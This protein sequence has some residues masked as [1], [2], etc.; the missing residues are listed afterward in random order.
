MGNALPYFY[1]AQAIAIFTVAM[2]DDGFPL[3]FLSTERTNSNKTNHF[4]A[5]FKLDGSLNIQAFSTREDGTISGNDG[6]VALIVIDIAPT[7]NNG[8]YPVL[9]K[10]IAIADQNSVTYTTD[11]V[12]TAITIDGVAD[13]RIVL[14][15]T[16]ASIPEGTTE[17]VE[18]LVKRTIKSD[19][20]STLCLPFSMTEDQ[21]T[22]AFGDDVQLAEFIDY[23]AEYD[24]DAVTSISVNFENVN[25]SN[26]LE[27]NWPYLIK[28]SNLV[29]EFSLTAKV[30]PDEDAAVAEYD[31]G[32]TGKRRVVWGQ[33]IG[34]LHAGDE[35]PNMNLFISDNNF[36]Y[37]T[38]NTTIN[39][40]R[41]YLWFDDKLS[42][43]ASANG[44]SLR[45]GGESTHVDGITT[46]A[47]RNV[48]DLSGR[49]LLSDKNLEKGV[50]I[51]N[52]KKVVVK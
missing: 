4:D 48:Y 23:D 37:S 18:L 34:T 22:A 36:Y 41:A 19:T 33:F 12:E 29:E 46:T 5:D 52:S 44:I 6:E 51:M 17:A 9:L 31:N 43:T 21:L 47:E 28:V 15:E 8:T 13:T 27:A 35:I 49:K 30:E 25:L 26:G 1:A 32:L 16:S 7:V 11:E 45:I 42:D 14:S 2:D 3:A 24:G 10:N 40:F 39:A 50:Y 38:G 20:W